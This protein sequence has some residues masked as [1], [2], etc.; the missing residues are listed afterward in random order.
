M[1]SKPKPAH[2]TRKW[3]WVRETDRTPS[4][5]ELRLLGVVIVVAVVLAGL[6]GFAVVD[7]ALRFGVFTAPILP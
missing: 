1:T 4:L 3:E 2:W 5:L 6:A 7:W